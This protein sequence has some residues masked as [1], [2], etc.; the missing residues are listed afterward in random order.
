MPWWEEE[1]G[2]LNTGCLKDWALARLESEAPKKQINWKTKPGSRQGLSDD[3]TGELPSS[4]QVL[5]FRWPH[6]A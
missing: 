6:A 4:I 1:R 2:T 5:E 3:V